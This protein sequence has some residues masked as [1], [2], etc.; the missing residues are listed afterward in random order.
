MFTFNLVKFYF[1]L[2]IDLIITLYNTENHMIMI[3]KEICRCD[4]NAVTR[5]TWFCYVN[6]FLQE[7]FIVS[8]IDSALINL[9]D[10]GITRQ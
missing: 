1:K 5:I 9:C 2:F 3:V 7:H 8:D 10:I 4:L 6:T